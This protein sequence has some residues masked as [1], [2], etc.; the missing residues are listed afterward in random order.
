M[1]QF[2][3]QH[4]RYLDHLASITRDANARDTL[5]GSWQRPLCFPLALFVF[6]LLVC[7]FST[8]QVVF[9][10]C[11]VGHPTSVSTN[12]SNHREWKGCNAWPAPELPEGDSPPKS[13]VVWCLYRFGR[14]SLISR[15]W[16]HEVLALRWRLLLFIKLPYVAHI[17]Y[18]KGKC[19]T[20]I[21]RLP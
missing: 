6:I 16:T 20:N 18:Q 3:A 17:C 12:W 14:V 9:I 19:V 8:I 15:I 7:V 4:L 2:V 10:I 1:T 21:C 5:I 11:G 13:I